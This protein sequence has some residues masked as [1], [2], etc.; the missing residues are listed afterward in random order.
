MFLSIAY[1]KNCSVLLLQDSRVSQVWAQDCVRTSRGHAARKRSNVWNVQRETSHKMQAG[2]LDVSL[3]RIPL[4]LSA[5]SAYFRYF[6]IFQVS[7][8]EVQL[9]VQRLWT[10][11]VAGWE[12]PVF[13]SKW[14]GDVCQHTDGRTNTGARSTKTLLLRLAVFV[15]VRRLMLS[16]H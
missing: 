10:G 8:A 16:G 9:I 5:V 2:A 1:F 3:V 15:S 12:S 13:G 14:R 6:N 4:D 7:S 11:L